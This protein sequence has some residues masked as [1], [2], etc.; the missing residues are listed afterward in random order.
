MAP[1]IEEGGKGMPTTVRVPLPR[2]SIRDLAETDSARF[3]P[4]ETA[5]PIPAVLRADLRR[6]R[7][8]VPT[9]LPGAG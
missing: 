2:I 9:P 4:W 8:Q 6:T 3:V 7:G 1:E 5:I